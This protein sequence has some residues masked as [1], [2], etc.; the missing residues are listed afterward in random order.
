MQGLRHL[1]RFNEM[2]VGADQDIG[3]GM[4]SNI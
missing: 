2:M 4:T 1:I 3:T